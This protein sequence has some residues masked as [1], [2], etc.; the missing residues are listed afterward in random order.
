MLLKTT[1]R[2]YRFPLVIVTLYADLLGTIVYKKKIEVLYNI[3]TDH[4]CIGFYINALQE[5]G[6]EKP[7]SIKRGNMEFFSS[8]SLVLTCFQISYLI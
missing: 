4:C 2:Y 3:I 5:S 7:H 1:T 6:T 8:P